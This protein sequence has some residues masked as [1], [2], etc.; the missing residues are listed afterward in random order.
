MPKRDKERSQKL[1]FTSAAR[2]TKA[3][4]KL[5]VSA[6]QV[7]GVPKI[8]PLLRDKS[9]SLKP[10]LLAMHLSQD[11]EVQRFGFARGK[12]NYVFTL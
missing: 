7:A 2:K 12:G 1:R 10:V 4:R 11:P 6:D 8:T 5:G 3:L 9:R